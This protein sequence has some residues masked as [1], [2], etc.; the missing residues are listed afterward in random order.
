MVSKKHIGSDFDDFLKEEGLTKKEPKKKKKIKYHTLLLEVPEGHLNELSS[1]LYELARD[2][3]RIEITLIDL[4]ADHI[5][6]HIKSVTKREYD[7][8]K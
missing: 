5:R 4:M 3:Y 8:R 2:K 7:K 6:D 1:L